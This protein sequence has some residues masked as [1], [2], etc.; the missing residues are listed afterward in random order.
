[1]EGWVE[2]DFGNEAYVKITEVCQQPTRR[3]VIYIRRAADFLEH[4]NDIL[5]NDLRGIWKSTSYGSGHCKVILT[6][7]D[8]GS[9]LELHQVDRSWNSGVVMVPTGD[10]HPYHVGRS[11]L[12]GLK[13]VLISAEAWRRLAFFTSTGK[14]SNSTWV[15]Q[16]YFHG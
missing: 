3:N 16:W 4:I 14:G 13:E 5:S 2:T 1:M 8:H 10:Q 9:K 11:F 12:L 15:L 7:N 6:A